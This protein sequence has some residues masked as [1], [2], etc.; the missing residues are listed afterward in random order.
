MT[1]RVEL[2][3]EMQRA[4]FGHGDE[5]ILRGEHRDCLEHAHH[6]FGRR[7]PTDI[8]FV[9]DLVRGVGAALV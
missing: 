1:A 2:R 9:R 4:S 6:R 5:S 8:Y 7:Q 3:E